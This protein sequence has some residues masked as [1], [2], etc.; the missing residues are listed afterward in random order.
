MY[1]SKQF[2]Y[3]LCTKILYKQR[4]RLY[5]LQILMYNLLLHICSTSRP[6]AYSNV[7][8]TLIWTSV[9]YLMVCIAFP[10]NSGM[11][12]II[13]IVFHARRS[14]YHFSTSRIRIKIPVIR[15]TKKDKVKY[16]N[17]WFLNNNYVVCFCC[18]TLYLQQLS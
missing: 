11:R 9:Y 18:A 5:R 2:N 8:W 15:R 14:V 16:L 7:A 12:T 10:W 17:P 13:T 6:L 1:K 3:L 4:E